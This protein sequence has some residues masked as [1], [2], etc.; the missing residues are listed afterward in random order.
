MREGIGDI[1]A[2]GVKIASEKIGE[3]SEEFAIQ[4]KGLEAPAHDARSGKALAVAYGT[5]NRGMCHIHPL[6]G[7]AYDSGKFDFGMAKYGLPDPNTVHRWDEKGKGKSVK[8]LQ[9][10]LIVPDILCICKFFMYG[11]LNIDDYA[12]MLSALT[13]WEIDGWELLKVGER[14]TNLQRLFNMREGFGRNDDLIPKR[15][16]KIPSFGIYKDEQRCAIKDYEGMLNEYYEARG[17]D[18]LTGKP[19][20][21]KLR[22]LGLEEG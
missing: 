12:E 13:G 3:G 11:G 18:L 2:E 17:W 16:R 8:I 6:E 15:V 21:D 5:A 7:M 19:S 10:G 20:K 1:L 22:E 4:G 14:V 9:D